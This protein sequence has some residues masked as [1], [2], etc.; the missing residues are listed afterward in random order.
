VECRPAES[1]DYSLRWLDRAANRRLAFQDVLYETAA[2]L[3]YRSR[4]WM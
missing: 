3:L 4:S 2:R 1:R